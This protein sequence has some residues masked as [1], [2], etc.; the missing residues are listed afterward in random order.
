MLPFAAERSIRNAGNDPLGGSVN[1][2]LEEVDELR[3]AGPI[4]ILKFDSDLVLLAM[5]MEPFVPR[6]VLSDAD[7]KHARD[8]VGMVECGKQLC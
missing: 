8:V 2:R 7:I 6:F 4:G 1:E 5:H 3:S